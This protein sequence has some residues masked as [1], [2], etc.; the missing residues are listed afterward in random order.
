MFEK[1]LYCLAAQDDKEYM[2]MTREMH[3]DAKR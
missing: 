3:K 1:I 2:K